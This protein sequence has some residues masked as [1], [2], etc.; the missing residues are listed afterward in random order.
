MYSIPHHRSY[1]NAVSNVFDTYFN[2]IREV[3]HQV[4]KALKRDTPNWRVLNLDKEPSLKFSR[5]FAMDGNNLLKRIGSL[6]AR[7]IADARKFEESDY[8]L[9]NTFVDSFANEVK[10]CA[11]SGPN[12]K[13]VESTAKEP[14]EPADV[15]DAD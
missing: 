15:D 13:D 10:R 2:I 7:K 5:M 1:R 3:N 14:S 9:I 6:G 12:D 8:F 4:S 11:S